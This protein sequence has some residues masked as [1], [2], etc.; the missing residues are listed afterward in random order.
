[1][2]VRQPRYSSAEFALR[3]NKIYEQAICSQVET[4][5]QGEFVAIDIETGQW[6]MDIDDYTATHHL[7]QKLPDAQIWLV[8][9]GC[10]A[11][12]RIGAL[13]RYDD[14]V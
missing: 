11:T 1:M 10:R 3:G 8:R 6:A 5:H 4:D 14:I 2:I 9:V 13:H 12:Y 7:L